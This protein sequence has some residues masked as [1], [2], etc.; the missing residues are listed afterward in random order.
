M[1]RLSAERETWQRLLDSYPGTVYASQA[2]ERLSQ[3]HRPL[4]AVPGIEHS[5]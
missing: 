5:R 2:K 1:G 3:M 4:Q